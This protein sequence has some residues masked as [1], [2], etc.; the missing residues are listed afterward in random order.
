MWLVDHF[1]AAHPGADREAD[2]AG[3]VLRPPLSAFSLEGTP[4]YG[5]SSQ[6]NLLVAD[7][8]RQ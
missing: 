2:F 1:Y 8:H 6:L 5:C 4:G 7:K 3:L